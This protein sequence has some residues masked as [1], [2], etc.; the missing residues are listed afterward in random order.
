MVNILFLCINIKC[1]PDTEREINVRL[2]TLFKIKKH[3]YRQQAIHGNWRE[4]QDIEVEWNDKLCKSIQL[5]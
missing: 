5:S 4:K 2:I 3:T 1:M